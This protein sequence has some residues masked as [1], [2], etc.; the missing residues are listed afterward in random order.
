MPHAN[1]T[2]SSA[3][4]HLARRVVEHL[5]VLGGD[6]R[7]ELVAGASFSSSRNA[8]STC[9]RAASEVSRHAG[10]ARAAAATASST[11][12]CRGEVDVPGDLAGRR[13]EHLAG[14]L[15]D[16]RPRLAVDPVADPSLVHQRVRHS[17]VASHAAIA[18]TSASDRRAPR[19][20]SSLGER[21]RRREADDVAVQAALADEQAARAGLLQHRVA[22][23]GGRASCAPGSTSSTPTIRPLPR[24]SPT[25]GCARRPRAARRAAC[26][27]SVGG[28]G[29]QV[30]VEQV[31]QHRVG[32]GRGRPGCRRTW[33]SS[34]R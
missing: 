32:A 10:N 18:S 16:A 5:A 25:T 12:D 8:N 3:A 30:V 34:W 27:P 6:D 4:R 26:A 7:G 29:L 23:A 21:H 1:S 31:V 9:E 13:V 11:S 24:T 33:R 20:A 17:L 2:I 19:P 15:G 28:V 14:P 22:A